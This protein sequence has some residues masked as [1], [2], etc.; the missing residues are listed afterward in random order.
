MRYCLFLLL[1]EMIKSFIWIFGNVFLGD[2]VAIS[3][4][5]MKT[6]RITVKTFNQSRLLPQIDYST[7]YKSALLRCVKAITS[8]KTSMLTKAM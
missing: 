1:S 6:Y 8:E 5:V 7:N 2:F 3:L 4:G